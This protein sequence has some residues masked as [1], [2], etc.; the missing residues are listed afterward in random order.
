[1]LSIYNQCGFCTIDRADTYVLKTISEGCQEEL[2]M[3]V[4][5]AFFCQSQTYGFGTRFQASLMLSTKIECTRF[6][7][8]DATH[9]THISES[10]GA[11]HQ[12]QSL[13]FILPTPGVV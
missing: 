10:Q 8:V 6:A 11:L 2:L 12:E 3:N 9:A 7:C 4:R 5:N 1:M 13:S